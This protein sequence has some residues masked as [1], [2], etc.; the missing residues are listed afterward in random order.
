MASLGVV[1]AFVCVRAY[2]HH[3]ASSEGFVHCDSGDLFCIT[4]AGFVF[5]IASNSLGLLDALSFSVL[6]VLVLAST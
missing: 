3:F 5:I 1:W 6:I 4:S 2:G